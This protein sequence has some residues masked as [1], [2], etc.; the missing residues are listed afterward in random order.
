MSDITTMNDDVPAGAEGEL[1]R[2]SQLA[3]E[4]IRVIELER[5]GIRDGDGRGTVRTA[6]RAHYLAQVI[7]DYLQD[8]DRY[9]REDMRRDH[10]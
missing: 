5:S 6:A 3:F 7:E 10:A 9:A 1:Q 8:Y 2:L 4:L